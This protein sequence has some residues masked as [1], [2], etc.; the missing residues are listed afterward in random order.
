VVIEVK[1]FR[2]LAAIAEHGSL[3]AAAC[4]LGY[5]QPAVTQQIQVL[6][7]HLRTPVLVRAKAGAGLTEAGQVLLR[8]G[9]QV[10]ALV[11]RA[12]AEIEAVADLR[13]GRVRLACFPSVSGPRTRLP[14]LTCGFRPRA[15]R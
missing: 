15:G 11:A 1:H 5:S 3:S 14:R 13:A 10:L 2:L 7:R 9:E 6:E 8:H 4:S 12:R